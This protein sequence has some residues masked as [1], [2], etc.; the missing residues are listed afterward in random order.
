MPASRSV[1]QRGPL[2]AVK[3]VVKRFGGHTALD[4]VSL[5]IQSGEIIALA[6]ENGAGY[7]K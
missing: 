1:P 2:L 5:S 4:G 6:G 7:K 3:G